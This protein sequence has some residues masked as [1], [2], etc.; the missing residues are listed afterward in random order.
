[1]LR[2]WDFLTRRR[3]YRHAYGLF[4]GHPMGFETI[5][6]KNFPTQSLPLC[7][8]NFPLLKPP[9]DIPLMKLP[10]LGAQILAYGLSSFEL[11][12]E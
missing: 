4:L 12:G 3:Q 7:C 2:W 5:H 1:M 6:C 8:R 11:M 9:F 10:P